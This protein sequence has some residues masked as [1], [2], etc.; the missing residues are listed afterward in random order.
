MKIEK[1]R[2]RTLG[3]RGLLSLVLSMLILFAFTQK[4]KSQENSENPVANQELIKR[5]VY[6]FLWT[7]RGDEG[8]M[9]SI[10]RVKIQPIINKLIS[11]GYKVYEDGHTYDKSRIWQAFSPAEIAA[12]PLQVIIDWNTAPAEWNACMD[13]KCVYGLLWSSHGYMEPYPGC[14]DAE[15]LNFESRVL[16]PT[17][18]SP[19]PNNA[20]MFV[21]ACLPKITENPHMDFIVIHSCGSGGIE[22]DP[23]AHPYPWDG[24]AQATF[25]RVMAL[26]PTEPKYEAIKTWTTFDVLKPYCDYPKTYCL[27]NPDFS[28]VDV[29]AIKNSIK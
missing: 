6:L 19:A 12:H 8:D 25:D 14:P 18:V 21:R 13:T 5:K 9:V 20:K 27:A 16:F 26:N 3:A 22:G 23:D 1:T 10:D 28:D 15:L 7:Q 29:D 4:S 17:T 24:T 2:W 11:M